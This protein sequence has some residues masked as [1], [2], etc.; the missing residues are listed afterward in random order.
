MTSGDALNDRFRLAANAY[1]AYGVVYWVGGVWLALHGVGVRGG[2]MMQAGLV[3]I[4]LGLVLVVGIPLLLRRPRAWFERW[5]LSRRDFARIITL[6]MAVRAFEVLR[7]ALRPES[8]AVAAPWGGEVSFRAG[9]AVFFVVTL[10][11]LAL[12]ARAAWT[13]ERS[14]AADRS[15]GRAE[16]LAPGTAHPRRGAGTRPP[17]Q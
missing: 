14:G 17:R 9:A 10:A 5:V 1:L 15:T 12:V 7:V 11:A 4:V 13:G 8:A 2:R 16:P 6:L 3:W